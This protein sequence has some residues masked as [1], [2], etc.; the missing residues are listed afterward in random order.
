LRVPARLH[1]LAGSLPPGFWVL[2][3]GVLLNRA[4]SFVVG[5]LAL[6][7]VQERGY[8]VAAAGR[9]VALYGVGGILAAAAG[10]TMADKL[11]RRITMMVGLALSAFSVGALAVAR[12]PG[13]VAWLTFLAGAAGQVYPPALNAAVA[14]LV[15]FQDRP[16]AFGLV[17]W[18]ANVGFG[19]GFA[20]AAAVGPHSLPALFVLDA[21][22]TAGF[23]A[24]V[25]WRLPETRPA[26]AEHHPALRGLWRVV[27]DGPFATFLGL[28]LVILLVFT[29]WALL[30][31]LDTAAHG[32]GRG[33]YAL[34]LCLNCVGAIV[35]QPLLSSFIALRDPTRALVASAL[36]LGTGY[37]LNAFAA[38]LPLYA[39][40]VLLWTVGEVLCLPVASA[41]AA[42]LAPPELRGRYQ[43]VY[44]LVFSGAFALSPFLS[45]ELAA[46]AGARTVWLACFAAGV[47]VALGQLAV[48]GPRR[49]RLAERAR[50]AASAE[51]GAAA[52]P[53]A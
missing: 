26:L 21:A 49:R 17:Y 44:A 4:A 11:G 13:L 32:V 6:F 5:F 14:D 10:G 20:V 30:L 3:W 28:H 46:R 37:G 19:V 1:A 15:P 50:Q 31:G 24:L 12:A 35:L 42:A 7:L 22:T 29:Q 48:A 16:R 33:G 2:W 8:G 34:L 45:G 36:F 9:V 52:Q 40:G 53:A 43:G 51:G 27:T 23:L 18:A 41:L 38:T 47:A 39:V 25:A